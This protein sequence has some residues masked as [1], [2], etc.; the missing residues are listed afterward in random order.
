MGFTIT[1]SIE[2]PNGISRANLYFT[3][4]GSFRMDKNGDDYIVT[5]KEYVFTNQ[6]QTYTVFERKHSTILTLLQIANIYDSVYDWLKNN[7]LEID[8]TL[9]IVDN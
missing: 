5:F 9:T 4:R 7:Y 2:L 3:I 8:D 6:D 1:E